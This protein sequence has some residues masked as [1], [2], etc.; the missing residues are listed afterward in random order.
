MSVLSHMIA[1]LL[2]NEIPRILSEIRGILWYK[3]SYVIDTYIYNIHTSQHAFICLLC[4]TQHTHIPY[5]YLDNLL[6]HFVAKS[7]GNALNA[8]HLYFT[9]WY[10]HVRYHVYTNYLQ[11]IDI[12]HLLTRGWISFYNRLP[13]LWV[14]VA[15][16]CLWKHY[17]SFCL[18]RT[19]TW[20]VSQQYITMTSHEHNRV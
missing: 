11:T 18:E 12:S 1:I 4:T 15:R 13:L 16:F 19:N 3:T 5:V 17:S 2:I 14:L 10:L 6:F 7:R 8:H 9:E 20:T